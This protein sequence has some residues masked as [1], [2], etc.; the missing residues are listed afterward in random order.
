M[1]IYFNEQFIGISLIKE[2]VDWESRL[3]NPDDFY[4]SFACNGRE[5]F[6]LTTPRTF[7]FSA[8]HRRQ[9]AQSACAIRNGSQPMS[10]PVASRQQLGPRFFS[11]ILHFSTDARDSKDS[12]TQRRIICMP[13]SKFPAKGSRE[14]E[15][16]CIEFEWVLLPNQSRFARSFFCGNVEFM[17]KKTRKITKANSV[18]TD[19]TNA[20][21]GFQRWILRHDLI[22]RL[23]RCATSIHV[24]VSWVVRRARFPRSSSSSVRACGRVFLFS[25]RRM[26]SLKTSHTRTRDRFHWFPKHRVDDIELC[27]NR[28]TIVD[29]RVS[30]L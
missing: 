25:C 21:Q 7:D 26:R 8:H 23:D 17:G 2:W 14:C 19:W 30:L 27:R 13:S 11:G 1:L 18:W 28:G 29:G 22:Q 5:T 9:T 20:V 12:L 6:T 10:A 24:C 4:V 3:H 16:I 15:L